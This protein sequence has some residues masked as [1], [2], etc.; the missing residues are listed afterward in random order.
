MDLYKG[1]T[2]AYLKGR[3]LTGDHASSNQATNPNRPA[4]T[5]PQEDRC[6]GAH[7][8]YLS[9]HNR[10]FF[11]IRGVVF[12]NEQTTVAVVR[13]LPSFAT[14]F[15]TNF[16][17]TPSYRRFSKRPSE[18]INTTRRRHG[19]RP[20]HG[21][22]TMTFLSSKIHDSRGAVPVYSQVAP[23]STFAPTVESDQHRQARKMQYYSTM[24]IHIKH[25]QYALEESK[26]NSFY[27]EL[28]VYLVFLFVMLLTVCALQV[29]IPFEHNDGLYSLY[30]D[31][32]FPSVSFKKTFYD[33]GC[34]DELWQWVAGVLVP[35]VFNSTQRNSLR[36]TSVQIRFGRVQGVPCSVWNAGNTLALVPA[37]ALCF[38]SF[39]DGAEDRTPYGDN[40]FGA[41][42]IYDAAQAVL[43]RSLQ[44]TPNLWNARMDYGTG[45]YTVYLPRDSAA[46]AITIVQALQKNL[47]LP[48]TRYVAVSWVLYNPNSDVM[49]HLHALFEI[50]ATDR[51]E[52]TQRVRSFRVQGYPSVA[53]FFTLQ[54]VLM[55]F[56]ALTTIGFTYRELLSVGEIGILQYAESLWN[57]FDVIQLGCLYAFVYTWFAYV[58]ACHT[59]IPTLNRVV[60]SKVCAD[61]ATAAA[62]FV[63]VG[64][65]ALGL[66]TVHNIGATVAL[67]SVAIVFKY[68]RLNTRLNLLWET[69]RIAAKDLIAFVVIFMF[70]FFG[71]AIMG[72]LLFGTHS[73]DYRSLADS[74][75]ACFQML[76]GAF[77]Y[78]SLAAANPVMSALFF[79]SF[80]ILVFL[81]V[82]NMFV[83]ILSEY[84][85]FASAAKREADAKKASSR[86]TNVEYDLVKQMADYVR[87]LEWRVAFRPRELP[88]PLVG[89]SLVLL[90]DATYLHAERARLRAKFRFYIG[91][92]RTCI[93]WFPRRF[94]RDAGAATTR[95]HIGQLLKPKPT[96]HLHY[97][98]F[99]V[100]YIPLASQSA[101]PH[102]MIRQLEPGAQLDIDDGSLTFARISL[103]VLGPQALYL[104]AD[105]DDEDSPKA[106]AST[107][108]FG[109][110]FDHTTSSP[111]GDHDVGSGSHIKCCRVVYHGD[112]ILSGHETLVVSRRLWVQYFV[113]RLLL[114]LRWVVDWRSA[115]HQSKAQRAARHAQ[116]RRLLT[117]DDVAHVLVETQATASAAATSSA[118]ADDSCRFDELVRQFRHVLAKKARH[119]GLPGH[120]LEA[121]ATQEAI[122]F[123]ERF[124]KALRP[125]DKRELVGYK[126]VPSPTDTSS[127]RLPNSIARLSEFLAQNAHEV[128]SEARIAQGWK[129]G[130]H[131]DNDKQLHPDLLAYSQ[132]SDGAKQYDRDTSIETLKIIQALGY[133][134][135]PSVSSSIS[136]GDASAPSQVD[137]GQPVAPGETYVP[138]PIATASIELSDE[139][140][141]LVEL[142]AENTHDVW[143]KK[144]M[145]EGWVYGPR[146]N[147]V[148]KEHDGLVPYVYLTAEEKDMD[149]NTAI[150]TVKCILRCGFS[151]EQKRNPVAKFR[152]FGQ[153][154]NPHET[155]MTAAAPNTL[156]AVAQRAKETILPTTT[157]SDS[158]PLHPAAVMP[159]E[160]DTAETCHQI[161]P[162]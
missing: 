39:E 50:S 17:K 86:D 126:Y 146:R 75:V 143:A 108:P 109:L 42:F 77:D 90:V 110:H 159:V 88:M 67:V 89:D 84:Y 147:D 24:R 73:Q 9:T 149:R 23:Q 125:L 19:S 38:P 49:S 32:E 55:L 15:P 151:V 8:I 122:A 134:M 12:N 139:L 117:D 48:S 13:L 20:T 58:A 100:T 118:E 138:K 60:Q 148:T 150:Q 131:R 26:R 94:D 115:W 140:K 30:F 124:P 80:M 54:N 161:S 141:S 102:T 4:K 28:S 123:V 57:Y 3:T 142:L 101:V 74:L 27:K 136:G 112:T 11:S 160:V 129:W 61:A 83:A 99:P 69:L 133:S 93:Y 87:H 68:L 25:V 62:C 5:Q 92:V 152:M 51:I 96:R 72:F 2:W 127:V 53:A 33:V 41:P 47:V 36:V 95:P 1:G 106:R 158:F 114:R 162:T 128:W 91:V 37:S 120:D 104:H 97:T 79:F 29:Q 105:D 121:A 65:L 156:L 52:T 66:E 78:G 82:V 7:S 70:I 71:Y 22:I 18:S 6:C 130:V 153:A 113:A 137:F 145:E 63:D 44:V 21:A 111:C 40:G 119:G 85:T 56:L 59:A 144:R 155:T 103:H 81:I 157:T 43:V 116:A 31:Q 46:V 154:S 107:R 76:L 98:K 14:S 64:P 45:G 16:G 35:G 10:S 132:L 34:V 135:N